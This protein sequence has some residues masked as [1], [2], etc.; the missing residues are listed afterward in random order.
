M[1][2][3]TSGELQFTLPMTTQLESTNSSPKSSRAISMESSARSSAV[4]EPRK[5]RSE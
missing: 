3:Q 2:S 4:M 1:A 5:A